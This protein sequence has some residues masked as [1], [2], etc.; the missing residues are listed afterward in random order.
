MDFL[1]GLTHLQETP[2]IRNKAEDLICRVDALEKQYDSQPG[3]VTEQR[4][5]SEV[6]RYVIFFLVAFRAEFLL[7]NAR[8]SGDKYGLFLSAI[9]SN[10]PTATKERL[11]SSSKIYVKL[12]SIIRFVRGIGG[13]FFGIDKDN[14]R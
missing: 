6:V 11:P 7:A 9:H 12:S 10:L 5:R 1:L 3:T 14:R 4:R 2:T 13:G 8:K